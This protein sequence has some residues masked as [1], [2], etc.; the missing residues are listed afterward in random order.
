MVRRA[1]IS[2]RAPRRGSKDRKIWPP[3]F[4]VRLVPNQPK[5]AIKSILAS[6]SY[7]SFFMT[8]HTTLYGGHA[9]F[10]P[11]LLLCLFYLP[12]LCIVESW[13]RGTVVKRRSLTGELSLSCSTCSWWVTTNDDYR[14]IWKRRYY[15]A[16]H[17]RL[18][19]VLTSNSAF[20]IFAVLATVVLTRCFKLLSF[21][22]IIFAVLL[23]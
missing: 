18:V 21:L 16:A 9:W 2:K 19:N 22:T 4:L 11:R 23:I 20:F 17:R 15:L 13:W 7:G 1:P 3:T 12:R 6:E 14:K 8:C 10:G 5:T